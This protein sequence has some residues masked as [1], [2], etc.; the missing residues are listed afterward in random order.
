MLGGLRQITAFRWRALP[1][2][3]GKWNTVFQRFRRRAKKGVWQM[4]F[5]TLA[6][7]ADMEW[8]M[9]DSTIIRSHQY[10][11][12]AK[13]AMHTSARVQLWGF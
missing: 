3:Y 7:D 5:N 6:R 12:G 1:T 9:I 13:G 11:A 2:E 4:I 8:V 10:T